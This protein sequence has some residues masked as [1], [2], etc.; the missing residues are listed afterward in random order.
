METVAGLSGATLGYILGNIPEAIRG[1]SVGTG[2]YNWRYNMPPITRRRNAAARTIQRSMRNWRSSGYSGG[3]TSR[4]NLI[5]R[6][7]RDNLVTRQ[8][9]YASQ[10]KFKK[11]PRYKKR[12]WKK[13]TK[14]VLA[15][16]MKNYGKQTVVLNHRMVQSTNPGF[17]NAIA[18]G[19]YGVN[20]AL[21]SNNTCG[22]DDLYRIFKNEPGIQ[23]AGVAPGLIPVSGKLLFGSGVIDYTIRNLSADFEAEV[24]IY[25][26]WYRSDYEDVALKSA[27]NPITVYQSAPS[28]LI[29]NGGDTNLGQRGVT[30]FDKPTG[31]SATGY[32]VHK[33]MKVLLAPGQS[34]FYQ[35]RDPGNH[36]VDW[37]N[38]EK[39]GFAK[40][41]L[42]YGVWIIFKPTVSSV[43]DAVITLAV[44]CTRKY[45]YT[46]M[47]DNVDKV[48]YNPPP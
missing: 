6:G 47:E 13:F 41:K 23:R 46:V 27:N 12:R 37:T 20:G 26:G 5:G 36:I 17:Q 33:K 35:H 11:M 38:V 22:F 29:E 18:L 45:G 25:T 32:H 34:S 40:A 16:T 21:D 39:V 19:L 3:R 28:T 9:D 43:E 8:K 7:S 24:D 2:L 44:G 48:A 14:K 42:T 31:I 15:V 10:Y 30:L 4:L 1:Y